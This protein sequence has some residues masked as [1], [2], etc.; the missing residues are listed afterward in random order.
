MKTENSRVQ[1]ES[2]LTFDF[3][4]ILFRTRTPIERSGSGLT[5]SDAIRRSSK[6]TTSTSYGADGTRI[7][8]SSTTTSYGSS[9]AAASQ[10]SASR[11]WWKN[12]GTYEIFWISKKNCFEKITIKSLWYSLPI[13][14]TKTEE[15]KRNWKKCMHSVV[16]LFEKLIC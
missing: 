8:Q 4:W 6:T 9:A 14:N 2:I 11:Q 1:L 3:Y 13:K 5:S 7:T 10:Q 16:N 15:E 12:N